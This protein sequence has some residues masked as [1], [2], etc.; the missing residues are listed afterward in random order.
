[1]INEK[2]QK[3]IK[4]YK[5]KEEAA[6]ELNDVYVLKESLR[7]ELPFSIVKVKIYDDASET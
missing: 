6:K 1:M 2:L 4:A 7:R 3:R 5:N